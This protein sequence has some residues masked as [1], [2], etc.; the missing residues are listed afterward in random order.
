MFKGF[1][2]GMKA[3]SLFLIPGILFFSFIGWA[4]PLALMF[5]SSTFLIEH[6]KVIQDE[7]WL[8]MMVLWFKAMV[9]VFY[10]DLKIA[11][12]HRGIVSL[13]YWC[14]S[15][16]MKST[17]GLYLLRNLRFILFAWQYLQ[18]QKNRK[19]L[20]HIK[21]LFTLSDHIRWKQLLTAFFLYTVVMTVVVMAAKI[22]MPVPASVLAIAMMMSLLVTGVQAWFEEVGTRQLPLLFFSK[23][24]EAGQMSPFMAHTFFL[25][26]SSIVFGMAHL[27]LFLPYGLLGVFGQMAFGLFAGLMAIHLSGIEYSTGV[28][29]AHNAVI[30][31]FFG[32]RV[33][34]RA[35]LSTTGC[36][37]FIVA[38]V[39]ALSASCYLGQYH[40]SEQHQP[41]DSS[42]NKDEDKGACTI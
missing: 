21:D 30:Y 17:L 13:V 11:L 19:G 24:I 8:R 25:A 40:F 31:V 9:G 33:L 27:H 15:G 3:L 42:L 34:N 26:I 5:I 32:S 29:A 35:V 38:E 10:V 39:I 23:M 41:Q 4:S 22:I 36:M 16:V 7:S 18:W 12:W 37:P 14:A 28:H 20:G 6:Q 2:I 1:N